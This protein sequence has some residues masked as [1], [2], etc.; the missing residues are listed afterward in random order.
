MFLYGFVQLWFQIVVW[1][2]ALIFLILPFS[3]TFCCV[4]TDDVFQKNREGG[5]VFVEQTNSAVYCDVVGLE[6]YS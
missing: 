2:V 5:L 3:I 4:K 6:G 1:F